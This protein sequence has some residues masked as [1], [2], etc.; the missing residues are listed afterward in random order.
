M[1][2]DESSPLSS[3]CE[4]TIEVASDEV[5][6]MYDR[7]KVEAKVVDDNAREHL[8]KIY[9][10]D[11]DDSE[12]EAVTSNE[13]LSTNGTGKWPEEIKP[14]LWRYLHDRSLYNV[15]KET[16]ETVERL[17]QDLKKRLALTCDPREDD[18]IRRK[19]ERQIKYVATQWK[20][21]G[22][23]V[24]NQGV[25][26]RAPEFEKKWR[27]ARDNWISQVYHGDMTGLTELIAQEPPRPT[28]ARIVTS[29]G[30]EYR[31][32]NYSTISSSETSTTVVKKRKLVSRQSLDASAHTSGEDSDGDEDFVVSPR[33]RRSTNTFEPTSPPPKPPAERVHRMSKARILN[34]NA[35]LAS[36]RG[37]ES[38]NLYDG[39]SPTTQPMFAEEEQVQSPNSLSSAARHDSDEEYSP[40]SGS[41][42]TA[43]RRAGSSPSKATTRLTSVTSSISEIMI[44][45]KTPASNSRKA[46]L[47][48]IFEDSKDAQENPLSA[49]VFRNSSLPGFFDLVIGKAFRKQGDVS[50]L[51]FRYTWGTLDAF[52]IGRKA[53]EDDWM[54]VKRKVRNKFLIAREDV[55]NKGIDFEVWVTC[56]DTTKEVS[57]VDKAEDE[58]DW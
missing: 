16:Y 22:L 42:S 55:R 37:R 38:A 27:Q 48:F 56:G 21:Y 53:S 1:D 34:V 3:P 24:Q 13:W 28:S 52:V 44:A 54:A 2:L 40:V 47:H 23:L 33:K 5:E 4:S 31:S 11:P 58:D 51:T 29:D 45:D 35:S 9:S 19:V 18:E 14:Y 49:D 26:E 39:R 30:K 46:K 20:E 32:S 50:C 8:G 6:E 17:C 15:R 12:D 10:L 7:V 57:V 25:Y 43:R 36:R 41:R